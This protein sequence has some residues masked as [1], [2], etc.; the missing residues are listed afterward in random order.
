LQPLPVQTPEPP[1]PRVLKVSYFARSLPPCSLH[2]Q[3]NPLLTLSRVL[4]HPSSQLSTYRRLLPASPLP[5][6]TY[7]SLSVPWILPRRRCRLLLT[8]SPPPFTPNTSVLL[9]IDSLPLQGLAPSR[10]QPI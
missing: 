2:T 8:R 6:P 4:P 9:S 1:N 5:D 10:W 7:L 3:S